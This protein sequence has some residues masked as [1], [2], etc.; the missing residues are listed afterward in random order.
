MWPSSAPVPKE[1]SR[2][3]DSHRDGCDKIEL[4]LLEKEG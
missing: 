4:G 2:S 1:E 3:D